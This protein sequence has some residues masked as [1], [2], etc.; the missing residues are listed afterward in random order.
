MSKLINAADTAELISKKFNIPM[1]DLIDVFAEIPSIEEYSSV[2][3][4]VKEKMCDIYCRFPRECKTQEGL[5]LL[6]ELCPIN[7]WGEKND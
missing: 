2:P 6:C 4:S 3:L 1:A 7:R 5:E